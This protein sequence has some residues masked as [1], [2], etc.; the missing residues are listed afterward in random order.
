MNTYDAILVPG[1]GVRQGGELPIWVK[2]RFDKVLE[3]YN[4]ESIVALSAGTLLKPPPLDN[5][6]FPLFESVAGANYLIN[7]GIPPKKILVETCSYD[8]IGNAFFARMIHVDPRRFRR[9]LIIT[10]EFHMPRTESV[11]KWIFGLNPPAD[12]YELD[13]LPVSDDGM[14]EKAL[15]ARKMAERVN[16]SKLSLTKKRIQTL[17]ELHKWLFTKHDAYAIS[18]KPLG[19]H[20]DGDL[21]NTY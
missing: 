4:N 3:I 10:S 7:N 21:L 16:L 2:R 15:N 9:L 12:N 1:G 8:T 6:G 11:F 19:S 17:E 18:S 5:R 13:F 20:I 14:D